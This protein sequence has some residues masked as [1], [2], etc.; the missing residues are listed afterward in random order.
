MLR[1][2]ASA[3]PEVSCQRKALMARELENQ[4][5]AP[6]KAPKA[7]LQ[8]EVF[9]LGNNMIWVCQFM[10]RPQFIVVLQYDDKAMY[11][12]SSISAFFGGFLFM[13]D[14][15]AK[16]PSVSILNMTCMIWGNPHELGNPPF[17]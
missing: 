7:P 3:S 6:K 8:S 4:T 16:S 14:P 12:P 11:F 17:A 15:Q 1:L 2:K 9:N 13:G 10:V 5:P